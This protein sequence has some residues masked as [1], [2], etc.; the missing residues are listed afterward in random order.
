MIT[1]ERLTFKLNWLPSNDQAKRLT[2]A[3]FTVLVDGDAIWPTHFEADV[4][5]EIQVDDLLAHLTEFWKPLMLRQTYPIRVAP[6]RPSLLRAEAEKRWATEPTPVMERED[7]RVTAFEEAHDLSR[8]FAGLFGLP[9][10]WLL[11]AGEY[12]I[13]ETAT[14]LCRLR[15]ATVRDA[16]ANV[17]DEI[18]DRLEGSREE[19][20]T[21]L[22]YAWRRRDIGAPTVLLAWS[23]GLDREVAEAFVEQG[24]L[25]APTNV[26]DAA[27]DND[28]LR[29]AA[30]MASALPPEQIS[31]IIEL[32]RKFPKCDAPNLN[33]LSRRVRAYIDGAFRDHRPHEQG[34]AAANFVRERLGF[35]SV[36]FIDV[37]ATI[38]S[39]GVTIY[40]Q[41][42]Q[43]STLDALAVWGQRHGPAVLLNEASK[44]VSRSVDFRR[45]WVARVTLAHELS[46]LLLDGGHTLTAVDVL[47]SRMPLEVERR[48][49][50][51]A[52]ELLLPSRIAADIWQQAG[53][54]KSQ[55]DLRDCL[56]QLCKRYG[57]TQ[58]VAAWKLEHGLHHRDIDLRAQLN[59]IV[60]QR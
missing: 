36:Q 7:E 50:A 25:C 29:I 45:S 28:E 53:G 21:D 8:G 20:W 44:R 17:G 48:A 1:A 30:R 57:V 40:P 39:L 24:A 11:R 37:V 15:F 56:R 47:N 55:D 26:A 32:V 49:K 58:S 12:F 3:D 35:A 51:F 59:A 16:L 9:P 13:S 14:F 2:T 38:E 31:Q 42:V 54:P 27:N 10:L 5:L 43:P 22:I 6:E 41:P 18:A 19:R 60:P 33:D 52:G 46:H 23:T 4:R 34:E